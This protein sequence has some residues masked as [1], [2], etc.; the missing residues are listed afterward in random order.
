M[1]IEH[2]ESASPHAP[3][4]H[5][6]AFGSQLTPHLLRWEHV[7]GSWG[8]PRILASGRQSISPLLRALHYGQSIFEGLKAHRQADGSVAL[9]RP[10]AHL[11][12]FNRSAER[13]CLPALDVERLLELLRELVA[14]DAEHVPAPPDALY[15][16]PLLHAC[17]EDLSAGPGTRFTLQV[18]LAPVPAFFAGQSGLRLCT[19]TRFVRAFPGGTGMV[20]CA[21]NYAASML[22]QRR[23]RAE[24]FDE[25][26]WLDAL[27]RRYVEETGAMNLFLV[28]NGVLVTPPAGDTVL[29]GITRASLLELAA[30]LAIPAREQRVPVD[31]DAWRDVSEV[32]SSG[33]AVGCRPI[34]ELV[35][36]GR[37]LFRSDDPG[38][39][40]E[41]LS[42]RLTDIKE[43]RA[44]DPHG[45]RLPV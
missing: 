1:S 40:Q 14:L 12:R 44:S 24:G 17:D 31:A 29:A 10:R 25:V 5:R 4:A 8:E 43:G 18:L 36:E 41:R 38:P 19:E 23:A 20:K 6:P 9:F 11:E 16:R 45:W 35:H 39:I 27:E 26:V 34:R 2:P 3:S 32:F 15:V 42:H 13:M 21:G 28:K 30:D 22:A 7:G 33:T 37:T